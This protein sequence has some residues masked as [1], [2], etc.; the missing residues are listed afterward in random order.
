MTPTF[1]IVLGLLM[2]ALVAV[3]GVIWSEL[4]RNSDETTTNRI[5]TSKQFEA[6]SDKLDENFRSLNDTTGEIKLQ[7]TRTNGHVSNLEDR[8]TKLEARMSRGVRG[9]RKPR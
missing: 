2:T 1:G 9:V 6:Q 8:T 4:R 7:T 5:A 3:L